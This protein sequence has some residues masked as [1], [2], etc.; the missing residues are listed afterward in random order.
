MKLIWTTVLRLAF[1]YTGE[2]QH[3]WC[4]MGR[5][6]IIC[7][8]MFDLLVVFQKQPLWIRSQRPSFWSSACARANHHSFLFYTYCVP[9]HVTKL[10]RKG[11]HLNDDCHHRNCPKKCVYK[12]ILLRRRFKLWKYSKSSCL[13]GVMGS[14]GIKTVFFNFLKTMLKGYRLQTNPRDFI[15]KWFFWQIRSVTGLIKEE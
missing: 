5:Q 12:S 14:V 13:T 7:W 6:C 4:H 9:S 15:S 1:E 8:Q 10:T 3:E 11:F 2:W